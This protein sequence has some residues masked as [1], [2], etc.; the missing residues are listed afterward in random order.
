[1]KFRNFLNFSISPCSKNK[2]QNSTQ[3]FSICVCMCVSVRK[4]STKEFSPSFQT[5][6]MTECNCFQTSI[7]S[8]IL[9][10]VFFLQIIL[11]WGKWC[12]RV[13]GNN[14]NAVRIQHEYHTNI[15]SIVVILF[16]CSYVISSPASLIVYLKD[17]FFAYFFILAFC[18]WRIYHSKDR[19]KKDKGPLSMKRRWFLLSSLSLSLSLSW[20]SSLSL[21]SSLWSSA[22]CHCLSTR[23]ILA[24]ISWINNKNNSDGKSTQD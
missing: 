5:Q 22:T 11:F 9:L 16:S 24:S 12:N 3:L 4:T 1:M 8:S 19:K 14:S 20:L 17:H 10:L 23:P 6:Q 15:H 7:L 13:F 18:V 2:L 21:S